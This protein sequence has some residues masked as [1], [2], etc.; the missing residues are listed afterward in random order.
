M[1]YLSDVN[2]RAILTVLVE[3]AGGEVHITN[4]ELY[5][6]ML[7][8][9][10]IV[11]RFVVEET[12]GGVRVGLQPSGDISRIDDAPRPWRTNGSHDPNPG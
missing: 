2:L 3:R 1:R 8:D 5:G 10:G 6:A 12:G 11:E 7:P 9:A 4:E